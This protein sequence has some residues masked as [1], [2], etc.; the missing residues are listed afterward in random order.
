V[1]TNAD[2]HTALLRWQRGA[3]QPPAH[4]QRH[5]SLHC[6]RQWNTV[7]SW[8]KPIACPGCYRLAVHGF[9]GSLHERSPLR[10]PLWM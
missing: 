7:F 1:P 2:Q 4:H 8:P 5:L 10:H 6:P 9:C 3:E